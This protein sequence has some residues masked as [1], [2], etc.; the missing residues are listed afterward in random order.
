MIRAS[1]IHH[2]PSITYNKTIGVNFVYRLVGFEEGGRSY[3]IEAG[4]SLDVDYG[5][6]ARYQDPKYLDGLYAYNVNVAFFR[7]P[8]YRFFGFTNQSSS[9]DETNYTDGELKGLISFGRNFNDFY[10]VSFTE[11]IRR[12]RIDLGKVENIPFT[13]IYFGR[14]RSWRRGDSGRASVADL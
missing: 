2:G 1:E 14:T 4:H 13:G 9:G 6:S 11:R 5:F 12:V 8:T 3:Q 10:R 7:N